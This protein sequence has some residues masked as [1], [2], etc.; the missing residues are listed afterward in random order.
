MNGHTKAF[1]V[2]YD[3]VALQL[4][5]SW[6]GAMATLLQYIS[7]LLKLHLTHYPVNASV[8]DSE[9]VS[10]GPEYMMWFNSHLLWN[11]APVSVSF[12]G[13]K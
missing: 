6:K 12:A 7:D 2:V 8:L 1:S 10:I 13:R 3:I 11:A 4:L 5:L 9:F